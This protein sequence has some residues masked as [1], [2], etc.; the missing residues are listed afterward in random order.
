MNLYGQIL[1]CIDEFYKYGEKLKL[2]AVRSEILF[3][4]NVFEI[5]SVGDFRRSVFVIRKF[6][7]FGARRF[8]GNFSV[9]GFQSFSAPEIILALGI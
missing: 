9:F 5:S 8:V 2:F 7:T 1:L 3:G 6:P 4:E